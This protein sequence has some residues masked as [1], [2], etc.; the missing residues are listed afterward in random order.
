MDISLSDLRYF[1][2]I[3]ETGNISKAAQTLGLRQ[4]TLSGALRRLETAVG[5]PLFARSKKGV[6]LTREGEAFLP[7][8]RRLQEDW[9]KLLDRG[10]ADAGSTLSSISVGCHEVPGSYFLP[11]IFSSLRSESCE[12]KV[13]RI[14]LVSAPSMKLCEQVI[15]GQLD[16]AICS[17]V[18]SHPDLVVRPLRKDRVGFW[19]AKDLRRPLARVALFT[20]PEFYQGQLLIRALQK[21]GVHFQETIVSSSFE[22]CAA[23]ARA[24]LGVAI[25]PEFSMAHLLGESRQLVFRSDLPAIE[26]Q[27][28]LVYHSQRQRSQAAKQVAAIIRRACMA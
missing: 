24:G 11:R 15:S 4:S 23:M 19:A 16:F 25:L 6:W 17:A 8:A 22:I 10:G 7:S 2:L 1:A 5:A 9:Q 13:Q 28:Q 14:E 20:V 12:V 27:H 18:V 3:A 21:R 26:G